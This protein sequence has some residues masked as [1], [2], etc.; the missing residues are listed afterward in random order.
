M[1]AKPSSA[2]ISDTGKRRAFWQSSIYEEPAWVS[3]AWIIGPALCAGVAIY[4][5]VR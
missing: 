2:L 1:S 4:F 5:A 3:L